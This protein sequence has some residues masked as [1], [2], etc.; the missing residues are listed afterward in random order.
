[1]G[2][3][4]VSSPVHRRII[5]RPRYIGDAPGLAWKDRLLK[6]LLETAHNTW[7]YVTFLISV[8]V[9]WVM[10]YTYAIRPKR[11]A[12]NRGWKIRRFFSFFASSRASS[13]LPRTGAPMETEEKGKRGKLEQH[14]A[15]GQSWL[16]KSRELDGEKE[17]DFFRLRLLVDS[18][19]WLVFY[20][21]ASR[22]NITNSYLLP[23]GE[24]I[25][26]NASKYVEGRIKKHRSMVNWKEIEQSRKYLG[27]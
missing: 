1:M 22:F 13:C 8:R 26:L 20:V 24:R 23:G 6:L 17:E 19:V 10:I 11:V 12:A 3:R 14:C 9:G 2:R 27:K 25:L 21:S 16:L 15:T 5:Y 7:R 18:L 4:P